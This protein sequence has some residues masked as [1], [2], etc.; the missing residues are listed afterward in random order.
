MNWRKKLLWATNPEKQLPVGGYVL[1]YRPTVFLS[2]ITITP[3]TDFFTTL[4]SLI[5]HCLFF[6]KTWEPLLI[7]RYCYDQTEYITIFSLS[8][9]WIKEVLRDDEKDII[10]TSNAWNLK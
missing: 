8:T 6:K 9:G 1:T 5:D 10:T 7:E 3:K 2:Y 4:K